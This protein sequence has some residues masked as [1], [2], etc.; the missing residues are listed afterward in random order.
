MKVYWHGQQQMDGANGKLIDV[1]SQNMMGNN[2]REYFLVT[3]EELMKK[4]QEIW[5]AGQKDAWAR[6]AIGIPRIDTAFDD[7]LK[8]KGWDK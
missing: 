8:A 1:C 5:D 6:D 2:G 3:K 4:Y 7:F